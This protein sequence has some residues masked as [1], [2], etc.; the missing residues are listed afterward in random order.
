MVYRFLPNQAPPEGIIWRN[1]SI[2]RCADTSLWFRLETHPRGM[3]TVIYSTLHTAL[4]EQEVEQ[5]RQTSI[6]V[7][8]FNFSNMIVSNQGG[9]TNIVYTPFTGSCPFEF[10]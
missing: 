3:E 8:V 9:T 6:V 7:Q 1:G 4:Q 2:L 5:V 10:A